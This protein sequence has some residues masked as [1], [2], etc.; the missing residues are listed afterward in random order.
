MGGFADAWKFVK[1]EREVK[2][3]REQQQAREAM[4]QQVS[5]MARQ[6]PGGEGG[7]QG[8]AGQT[9]PEPGPRALASLPGVSEGPGPTPGG[10]D[11]SQ[12]AGNRLG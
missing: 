6:M 12:M 8:R 2:I 5:A 1:S 9:G 10:P 4:L 7:G 3:E 11:E